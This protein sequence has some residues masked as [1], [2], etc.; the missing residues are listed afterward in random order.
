MEGSRKISRQHGACFSI[1]SLLQTG[2]MNKVARLSLKVYSSVYPPEEI[3]KESWN[4]ENTQ[5]SLWN[6]QGF[7]LRVM[8]IKL[9]CQTW[10]QKNYWK[11]ILEKEALQHRCQMDERLKKRQQQPP[12]ATSY[13][14]RG[15][16]T[17]QK[18]SRLK[19]WTTWGPDMSH[20]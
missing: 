8:Q 2:V 9:T 4:Q 6:H 18:V 17:R 1:V 13:H 10:R 5:A 7:T 16:H 14:Y 20:T 19:S 15:S 3:H 12:I 11:I